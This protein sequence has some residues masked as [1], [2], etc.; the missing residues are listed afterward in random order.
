METADIV[1]CIEVS[2]DACDVCD[3]AV[4][5]LRWVGIV[6]YAFPGF[7][8]RDPG[9]IDSH[10]RVTF[11]REV[12]RKSSGSAPDVEDSLVGASV[13]ERFHFV[14]CVNRRPKGKQLA[15]RSVKILG[16]SVGIMKTHSAH[17]T[18]RSS[19]TQ[20][21]LAQNVDNVLKPRGF[22]VRRRDSAHFGIGCELPVAL[23]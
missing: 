7:V 21:R 1:G 17:S 9:K 15:V 11:S 22:Y 12:L 20:V 16:R 2:V 13:C 10:D 8:Y 4:Q 14:G 19:S 18:A 6:G 5:E 23:G 3:I